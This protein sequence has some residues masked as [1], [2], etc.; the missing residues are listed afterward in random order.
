M[1]ILGQ[2][3]VNHMPFSS[4]NATNRN[5]V[6]ESFNK[7]NIDTKRVTRDWENSDEQ[8][9]NKRLTTTTTTSVLDVYYPTLL[10]EP[11][12]DRNHCCIIKVRF[13]NG[14]RI[15]RNF[16]YTSSL[17]QLF[18]FCYSQLDD[19]DIHRTFR[20]AL[21]IPPRPTCYLDYNNIADFTF[22]DSGLTSSMVSLIWD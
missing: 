17:R 9:H 11:K 10:T 1:M 19:V 6:Y 22:A 2:T 18:A 12:Y 7:M 21:T 14:T 16:R 15:T 8:Q 13:P 20:L 5:Y 4:I 3:A